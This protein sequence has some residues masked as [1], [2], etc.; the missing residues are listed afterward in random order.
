MKCAIE[1]GVYVNRSNNN[2]LIILGLYVD[3]TPKMTFNSAS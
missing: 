3:T 2:E 1:H